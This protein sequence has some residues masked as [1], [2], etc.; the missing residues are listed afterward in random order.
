MVND[1]EPIDRGTF[2]ARA[3]DLGIRHPFKDARCYGEY[4]AY[5]ATG[6]Y[7]NDT[8]YYRLMVA[9]GKALALAGYTPP[10]AKT[11][12]GYAPGLVG[13]LLGSGPKSAG[14]HYCGL[15]PRDCDCY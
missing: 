13:D 14:C 15:D 9:R 10:A 3:L 4:R 6:E 12:P 2:E 1:I 5:Q 11:G 8:P 7:Y